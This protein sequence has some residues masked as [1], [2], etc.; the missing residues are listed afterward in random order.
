M[1]I[2]GAPGERLESGEQAVGAVY[3]Y[4]IHSGELKLSLLSNEDQ[5]KFGQSLQYNSARNLLAVGAPTRRTSKT[6]NVGAVYIYDLNIK[7]L[8]FGTPTTKILSK[9]RGARFGKTIHWVGN[10]LIVAAP[11]LTSRFSFRVPND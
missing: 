9:D 1:V 5:S 6:Y 3:G 7:N 4:D 11:S 2:I 8:E 10:A